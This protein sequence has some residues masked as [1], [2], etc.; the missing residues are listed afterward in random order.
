MARSSNEGA[1]WDPVSGDFQK[2]V[3]YYS[4]DVSG[5]WVATGSDQYTTENP[6]TSVIANNTIKYS[7]DTG[8]TWSN[9][10]GGFSM[11]GYDVV[12]GSGNWLAVGNDIQPSGYL[13]SLRWSSDGMNWTVVD[14]STDVLFTPITG[15]SQPPYRIGPI[16]FDGDRWNVVVKPDILGD[17]Y[18]RIYTHDVSTSLTNN[19]SV[20]DVSDSFPDPNALLY[21]MTRRQYVKTGNPILANFTFDSLPVNGVTFTSPTQTSYIFYQYMKITPIV[22]NATGVGR[23]Y[24]VMDT[25]DLPLG[26]V[27][28]PLNQTITGTPMRLGEKTI[29][30]YAKDDVGVTRL[31]LNTNTIIPR[32][33]KNQTSAGA[34]T[35]LIRQYTEVNAAQNARDR[36]VLPTETKNLGEFQ[37]PYKSDAITQSNCPTCEP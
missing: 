30:I 5:M 26:L 12:Y 27:F 3:G 6:P 20:I 17:N 33:V 29:T 2:E 32:I 31:I 11:N 23:V 34:Y 13:P 22:F 21:G 28:D 37:S 24:Y 25:D 18:P 16:S 7:S 35:S 8:L 10:T 15:A 14:L 9:A 19:W 36:R 1:T 4:L